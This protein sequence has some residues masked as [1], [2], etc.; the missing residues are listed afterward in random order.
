MDA[1]KTFLAELGQKIKTSR[2]R[3]GLSQVDASH[4][5]HIDYRHYQNIEGGKINLRLDTLLKLF[6]FYNLSEEGEGAD[7]E[8]FRKLVG[9]KSPMNLSGSGTMIPLPVGFQSLK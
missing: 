2:K 6:H 9:M 8:T 5:M 4:Q 3:M 7:F 1:T